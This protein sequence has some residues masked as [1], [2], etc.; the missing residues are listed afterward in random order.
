VSDAST[1]EILVACAVAA[2]VALVAGALLTA[3][4]RRIGAR[5]DLVVERRAIWQAP[6]TVL[7]VILAVRAV[8][9]AV[10]DR[11]EWVGDVDY[12][13][14]LALIAAIGWALTV[15]VLTAERALLRRHP[16]AGITDRGSRHVRTKVLLISRVLQALIVTVALAAMLW[17]VPQI[18]EVGV[19]LLASASVVAVIVGLA[20]QTT[21]GNLFAGMQIAFTDAIR[22]DDIVVVEEQWG[23]V[24]EITLTYVAVRVWDGTSVILPCTYFT[25]TPFRNWT[26][27]GA[28]VTGTVELAVDWSAPLDDMRAALAR[29]L[30]ASPRWDG[31]TG[32]LHVA[33][34]ADT[35]VKVIALISA[36]DGD[37]LEPLRWEVREGLVRFL[38][39]EH[40]DALPRARIEELAAAAGAGGPPSSALEPSG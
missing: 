25:T 13:L 18:R 21:L 2:V 34:A 4:V 37:A 16:E 12:V 23:K 30:E 15:L 39:D 40:P 10:V 9:A 1:P 33:D 26:H 17:T 19:G 27:R 8:L 7:L 20:A 6:L 35:I 3:L 32:E 38:Q 31:K 22:I 24:E 29:L 36:V 28:E 14:S 5:R 11:R